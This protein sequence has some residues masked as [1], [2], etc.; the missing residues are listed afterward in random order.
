MFGSAG[1]VVVSSL[2]LF[3]VLIVMFGS[4]GSVIVSSLELFPVLIVMFGSLTFAELRS[5]SLAA[6]YRANTKIKD[7]PRNPELS[8]VPSSLPG[9]G[10]A[11]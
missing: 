9:I 6:E 5:G 1:S 4:A 11:D 7:S 2:E 8:K 3:P 10:G